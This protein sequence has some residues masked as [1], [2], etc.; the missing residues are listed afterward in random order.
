MS[1]EYQHQHVE[2]ESCDQLMAAVESLSQDR[3]ELVSVVVDPDQ[4]GHWH[5][6]LKRPQPILNETF[7]S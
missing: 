2:L 5:G 4:P 1:Q 7:Q 6:F 3:W